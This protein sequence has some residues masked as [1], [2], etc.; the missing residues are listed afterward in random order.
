MG[1]EIEAVRVPV[2]EVVMLFLR[3]DTSPVGIAMMIEDSFKILSCS[4]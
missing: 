3:R 1:V 4:R 2:N